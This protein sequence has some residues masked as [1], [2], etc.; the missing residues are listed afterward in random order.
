M[1]NTLT[2][3]FAL[4][5]LAAC[6]ALPAHASAA[7][8]D[9][10]VLARQAALRVTHIKGFG[11]AYLVAADGATATGKSATSASAITNWSFLFY[12][13]TPPYSTATVKY[14]KGKFAAT[15]ITAGSGF[16]I[17]GVGAVK[18]LPTMTV[19]RALRIL[20]SDGH[21]RAFFIVQLLHPLI[22]PDSE[23]LFLYSKSSG[24]PNATVDTV[25]GKVTYTKV[26]SGP[27]NGGPPSYVV[28]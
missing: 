11:S 25:T 3:L 1:K 13:T 24:T 20:R 10:I 16:P 18:P 6:A 12:T 28:Y 19:T 27:A 17:I 22:S 23:Y 2:R 26:T 15:K 9:A 4:S 7:T 8:P 5:L 14:A 21:T